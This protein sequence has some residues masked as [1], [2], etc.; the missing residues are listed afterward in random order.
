[1]ASTVIAKRLSCDGQVIE[2]FTMNRET[3]RKIVQKR[4][5]KWENK[6]VVVLFCRSGPP[7]PIEKECKNQR[8]TVPSVLKSVHYCVAEQERE[9]LNVVRLKKGTAITIPGQTDLKP[10][11][12]IDVTKHSFT[13]LPGILIPRKLRSKIRK[14]VIAQSN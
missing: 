4:Q 2:K 13:P 1:M 12:R 7:V 6:D 9:R 8:Y 10:D 3:A 5:G 11:M 14:T